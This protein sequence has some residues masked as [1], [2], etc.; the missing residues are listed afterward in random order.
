MSHQIFLISLRAAFQNDDAVREELAEAIHR[1]GGFILMAA[2]DAGLV[3]AFDDRRAGFFQQHRAVET[4][5][6]LNLNPH[7]RAADKLRQ[8][9]AANV[10]AQLASRTPAAPA[11]AEPASAAPDTRSSP[12]HRPLTWHRPVAPH[13]ADATGVSISLQHNARGTP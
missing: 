3:A 10:A 1:S 5:G 13:P 6:G 4:C 8:L 7:G 2:G 11:P 9:F 12:R